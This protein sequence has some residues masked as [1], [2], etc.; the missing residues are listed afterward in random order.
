MAG[1][2]PDRW[3]ARPGTLLLWTARHGTIY[4]HSARYPVRA[5]NLH[6]RRPSRLMPDCPP[7]VLPPSPPLC[8]QRRGVWHLGHQI[9]AL[10]PPVHRMSQPPFHSES[11]RTRLQARPIPRKDLIRGRRPPEWLP[12]LPRVW[13]RQAS[14]FSVLPPELL[15]RFHRRP[16]PPRRRGAPSLVSAASSS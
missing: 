5:R 7:A 12:Y 15:T 3:K 8:R 13:A 4:E 16:R 1:R 10:G 14:A 2:H 6:S 9:Q 11:N